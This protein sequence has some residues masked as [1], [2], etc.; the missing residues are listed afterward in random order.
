LIIAL[1]ES[2]NIKEV[3]FDLEKVFVYSVLT[4]GNELLIV[5]LF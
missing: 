1:L 2:K 3:Y 5:L 4:R